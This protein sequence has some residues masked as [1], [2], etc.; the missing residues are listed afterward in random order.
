MATLRKD[1]P[2]LAV[3][4]TPEEEDRWW[5]SDFT[6]SV[7]RSVMVKHARNGERVEFLSS[8][9]VTLESFTVVGRTLVKG[10]AAVRFS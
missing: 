7:M 6:R 9:G 5:R 8:G 2:G 3:E 1:R 10:R 4:L